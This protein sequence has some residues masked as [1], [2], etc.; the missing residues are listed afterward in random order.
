MAP[1]VWVQLGAKGEGHGVTER[2]KFTIF[3][4]QYHS[5]VVSVAL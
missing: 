3:C 4:R 1:Q 5:E 2:R